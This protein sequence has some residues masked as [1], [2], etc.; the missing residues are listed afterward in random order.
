[1]ENNTTIKFTTKIKTFS[2]VFLVSFYIIFIF[3]FAIKDQILN[4]YSYLNWVAICL[5]ITLPISLLSTTILLIQRQT[6]KNTETEEIIN[7]AKGLRVGTIA[8]LV[9]MSGFLI[10]HFHENTGKIIALLG[11]LT[12]FIGL[13]IH[14]TEMIEQKEKRTHNKGINTDA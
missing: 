10:T 14:F 6:I 12:G 3:S 1:M 8:F 2:W 4:N 13:L 11:I 7:K 5:L 9:A